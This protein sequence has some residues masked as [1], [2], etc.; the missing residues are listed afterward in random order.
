MCVYIY[1]YSVSHVVQP[2]VYDGP[3][4]ILKGDLLLLL[5]LLILLQQ[6]LL[7][8]LLIIIIIVIMNIVT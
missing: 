7:L 2:K 5:L 3:Q 8:L 6:Q 4:E 1:I